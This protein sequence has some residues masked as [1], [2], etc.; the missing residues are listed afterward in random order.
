MPHLLS[1]G[2]HTW[3]PDLWIRIHVNRSPSRNP[4]VGETMSTYIFISAPCL[5]CKRIFSF[6]PQ[7]VPSHRDNTGHRQ[8]ICRYCVNL[9]NPKRIANG[10]DPIEVKP[11]AY[12]PA[13]QEEVDWGGT[14]NLGDGIESGEERPGPNY[15]PDPVLDG[16]DEDDEDDIDQPPPEL[17]SNRHP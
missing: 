3:R 14:T 2:M 13:P 17:Y 12:E 10:L 4:D 8:P 6:H 11:G 9:A 5:A 7:K 1:G 16:D 15:E